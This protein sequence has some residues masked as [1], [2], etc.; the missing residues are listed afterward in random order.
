M[1]SFGGFTQPGSEIAACDL[2]SRCCD[3]QSS[4]RAGRAT[5]GVSKALYAAKALYEFAL[6]T[7]TPGAFPNPWA[8]RPNSTGVE[9]VDL[10][11]LFGESEN[12]PLRVENILNTIGVTAE[13]PQPGGHLVTVE[14]NNVV[15]RLNTVTIKV[16]RFH[17][18]NSCI[19]EPR[20]DSLSVVGS[21]LSVYFFPRRY[22]QFNT[23]PSNP[24]V[25]Q[26]MGAVAPAE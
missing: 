10:L 16:I 2:G 1:G 4:D 12:R 6:G 25:R 3:R 14:S 5:C 8:K 22:R 19:G 11:C 20:T 9:A 21:D 15:R 17:V 13:R 18:D 26:R 24:N 7:M 23:A